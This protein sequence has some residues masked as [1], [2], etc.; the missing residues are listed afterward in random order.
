[1]QRRHVWAAAGAVFLQLC[2]GLGA[3][4]RA[5]AEPGQLGAEAAAVSGSGP[6]SGPPLPRFVSLK[7]DQGEP[8]RRTR[9]GVPDNV[10]STGG[11]GSPS[12]SS[13]EFDTSGER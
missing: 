3:S 2:L 13:K 10:G 1:M 5:Q 8:A 11:P 9:T 6:A 4:P 12:R 7:A